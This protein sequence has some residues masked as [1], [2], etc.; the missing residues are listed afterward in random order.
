MPALQ[1]FDKIISGDT[2][3]GLIINLTE[4][5]SAM[6]LTGMS[7]AWDVYQSQYGSLV[8]SL[9]SA[10]GQITIAS[11]STLGRF[12]ILPT[13]LARADNGS[14]IPPQSY[15]YRCKLT[16]DSGQTTTFFEGNF[17][18]GS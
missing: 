10:A 14:P 6:D 2:W 4:D 12:T 8:L 18:V 1:D 11:P 17:I 7:V 15:W 5:G 13:P 3:P 9:T 16:N